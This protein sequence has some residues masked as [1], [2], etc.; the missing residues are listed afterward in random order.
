MRAVVYR[1]PNDIRLEEVPEPVIQDP[2]DAIVRVTTASICGS[3]LHIVHG[4]VPDI[5]PGFIVGHEFTGVVD[6][7]GSAVTRFKPGT[8]CVGAGGRVVRPVPRLQEWPGQRLRDVA[9]SSGHGP[10]FGDLPGAQAEYVRGPFLRQH[11]AA[12]PGDA[13]RRAGHLRRRHPPDGLFGRGR[14]QSPP[15]GVYGGRYGGGVRAAGP[16]G[17][18]AVASARLFDPALIVVVDVER[19][20]SGDGRSPG[21]RSGRRRADAKTCAGRSGS[22]TEGR[23]AEYVVEAVGKRRDAGQRVA[24]AAAPGG[25]VSVVGVFQQPVTVNAPRMLAAI[26]TLTMGMGD[27]SRVRELIGLD[28]RSGTARPHPD[29]SRIALRFGD[30]CG[31][32]RSSTERVDGAIKILLTPAASERTMLIV[33]AGRAA[34]HRL[35][36]EERKDGDTGMEERY[37]GTGATVARVEPAGAGHGGT[38]REIQEVQ[39]R[40]STPSWPWS[41]TSAPTA[42]PRMLS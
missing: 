42:S 20:P 17:L 27:L 18:C 36:R 26:L 31:P 38:Y 21:R 13:P 8:G 1:G 34:R 32:T 35:N 6:E 5:E 39:Y 11:S 3:D 37:R 22:V 19:L 14:A 9:P 24:A 25:V 7:V 30:V 12:D 10:L 16:V 28:R 15:C 41:G 23:G 40:T 29:R 2:E 4:L 33:A